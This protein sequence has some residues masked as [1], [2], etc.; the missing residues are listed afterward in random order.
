[1]KVA[2]VSNGYAWRSPSLRMDGIPV[3]T[4][5]DADVLYGAGSEVSRMFREAT[6]PPAE[7]AADF[8]RREA[9]NQMAQ[10]LEALAE[11]LCDLL[12]EP[13]EV[14]CDDWEDR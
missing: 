3:E 11:V 4:R 9:A 6:R 13:G 12:G 8:A 2:V 14:G 10:G 7:I 5:A 1:M